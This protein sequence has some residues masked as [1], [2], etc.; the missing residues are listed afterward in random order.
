MPCRAT[1]PSIHAVRCGV[2]KGWSGG[3]RAGRG[4]KV[5]EASVRAIFP[6]RRTPMTLPD[7]ISADYT[8]R[9]TELAQVLALLVEARQ[10]AIVFGP[11]GAAKSQIAQQVAADTNRQYVGR[12]GA[13]AR[14]RR[15][16]RHPLARHRRPHP[17]G[18]A[19]VPAPARRSRPLAHQPRR[20]ALRCPARAG[21]PLPAGA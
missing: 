4:R 3:V 20:A 8:L 15:S 17:L 5:L 10:P 13:A 14:P 2:T 19:R 9:P 12:P 6:P 1:S 16:P 21:G 11:P 18:A 7:K